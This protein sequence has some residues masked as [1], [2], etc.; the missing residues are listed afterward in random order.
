MLTVVA[1]PPP[2][3][4]PIRLSQEESIVLSSDDDEP[5]RAK[6]GVDIVK[7]YTIYSII[8]TICQNIVYMI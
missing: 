5:A 1:K 3:R 6:V 8:Y 7:A 2:E 4:K